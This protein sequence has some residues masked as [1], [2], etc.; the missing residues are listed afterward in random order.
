MLFVATIEGR[1]NHRLMFEIWQ[2]MIEAGEDPPHLICVG[3]LG[4]KATEFVSA[5]VETNY[6]DGRV[7]LLRDISDADLRLLYDRCLF[8]VCPTLLRRVGPAGWR[9]AGDGQDLREQRS[10]LGP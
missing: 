2:R 9:I 5:L 3:R 8:T 6:L 10:C 1:K 4:W 7:H